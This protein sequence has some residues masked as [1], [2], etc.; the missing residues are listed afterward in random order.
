MSI[1]ASVPEGNVGGVHAERAVAYVVP[2]ALA[3]V[4]RMRETWQWEDHGVRPTTPARWLL[5]TV[6]WMTG[7]EA[8][9][10][11]LSGRLE[12]ELTRR[13]WRPAACGPLDAATMV[14]ARDPRTTDPI[15]RAVTLVIAARELCREISAGTLPQDEIQGRP[16]NMAQY[17]NLVGTNLNC[18]ESRWVASPQAEA[19]GVLFRGALYRVSLAPPSGDAAATLAADLRWIGTQPRTPADGR[20]LLTSLPSPIRRRSLQQRGQEWPVELADLLFT[21]CLDLDAQPP[22]DAEAGKLAQIGNCENRWYASSLQIVVFGNAHAAVLCSFSAGIDGNTM[23]RAAEELQR[24]AASVPATGI[25]ASRP[26]PRPTRLELPPMD[27]STLEIARTSIRTITSA[28][29]SVFELNGI[30]TE[31]FTRI[32]VPAV[33]AFVVALHSAVYAVSG[34]AGD[35]QQ[36]LSQSAFRGMGVRQVGTSTELMWSGCRVLN[37][38]TAAPVA[39]EMV[40]LAIAEYQHRSRLA[41][42]HVSTALLKQL[43]RHSVSNTRRE[44]NDWIERRAYW[45]AATC[46]LTPVRAPWR[47]VISHPQASANVGLVGRPGIQCPGGRASIHY[48]IRESRTQ[49]VVSGPAGFPI[50]RLVQALDAACHRLADVLDSGGVKALVD[51][52]LRPSNRDMLTAGAVAG[53]SRRT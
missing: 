6:W 11:R 23:M 20:T 9:A 34:L 12:N 8:F 32:G 53:R 42:R 43:H 18:V 36:F 44:W 47:I 27:H 2:E 17:G 45:L 19:I 38:G 25:T 26:L 30:G 3:R 21:L 15:A 5:N 10:A 49:L 39:A 51:P 52:P 31:F 35:I 24:R 50:A 28:Q 22:N 33:P 48:Q 7:R 37:E 14:L 4:P 13:A 29:E 1:V 46:R 16:A 40:R 41:R